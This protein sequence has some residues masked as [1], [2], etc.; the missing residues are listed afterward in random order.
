MLSQYKLG[1]IKQ[2]TNPY[3]FPGSRSEVL[4]FDD[5][6]TEC[7]FLVLH[8]IGKFPKNIRWAEVKRLLSLF[9]D[10]GVEATV[11][12]L[13]GEKNGSGTMKN[14]VEPGLKSG[15]MAKSLR[16]AQQVLSSSQS[17]YSL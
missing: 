16:S 15:V 1:L 3:D 11:K 4:I 13:V 6:K 17:I 12:N 8:E 2:R 7:C 14:I 10:S 5:L 9:A